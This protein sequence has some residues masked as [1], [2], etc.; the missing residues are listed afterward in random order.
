MA[1]VKGKKKT[2]VHKRKKM[3]GGGK[4]KSNGITN[5]LRKNANKKKEKKKKKSKALPR[6]ILKIKNNKK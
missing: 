5:I 3:Y 1:K 2:K 4:E 6:I